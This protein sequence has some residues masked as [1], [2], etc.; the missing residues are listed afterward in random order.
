MASMRLTWP[1]TRFAHVGEFAS[2]K[3][4]MKTRERALPPGDTPVRLR[5]EHLAHPVL[6]LVFQLDLLSGGHRHQSTCASY[7]PA[8]RSTTGASCSATSPGTI[9]C[10]KP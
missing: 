1:S 9:T 5:G 6:H 3:S 7:F 4:A 10:E 8:R 2:S